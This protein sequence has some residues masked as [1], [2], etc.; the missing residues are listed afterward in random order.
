M[1]R[2]VRLPMLGLLLPLMTTVPALAQTSPA[3]YDA[4]ADDK[5]IKIGTTAPLSGPAGR[6]GT[7]GSP[8]RR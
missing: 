5:T 6:G 2:L 3:K 4:G 8:P 7:A 1:S